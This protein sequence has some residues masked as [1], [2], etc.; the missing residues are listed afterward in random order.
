MKCTINF[1]R[2][3][4]EFGKLYKSRREVWSYI[5]SPEKQPEH[6]VEGKR[7]KRRRK[8][9]RSEEN[10]SYFILGSGQE[11]LGVCERALAFFCREVI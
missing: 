9:K 8:K 1:K 6:E 4:F 3:T 10:V 11:R 5:L 2:K 7:P